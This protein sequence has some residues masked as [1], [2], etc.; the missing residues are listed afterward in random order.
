VWRALSAVL[1]VVAVVAVQACSTPQRMPSQP[2]DQLTQ[3][4]VLGIPN[5]RYYPDEQGAELFQEGMMSVQREMAALGVT[6][7]S[8]LP[9]AYYLAI[10]GGGGD[11][12]FGAGLLNG[13]TEA[14]TRPE[15]KLVTGISTGSLIAPFAFLGSDYDAQLKRVYTTIQDSDVYTERG[16][17]AVFDSDAMLD[18]TPLFGIISDIVDE[19]MMAAIAREYEKGRMLLVASTNLDARQ[20]VIWN[21]GA[22]AASGKPGALDLIH[23]IL[24][25]SAAMPVGFPP[26]MFDVEVDGVTYQEMH[27]DGGAVAQLILYP[28]AVGEQA[29]AMMEQQHITRE[30]VAYVIRNGRLSY[31]AAPVDRSTLTIA[32]Q[33]VSTMISS[34]GINDLYRVYFICQE[35]GVD[36]NLAYIDSGF[37]EPEPDDLFDKA[38][39]NDLFEYGYDLARNGYP[40]KKAPPYLKIE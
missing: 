13:W 1:V 40:W 35:D 12:A 26:V 2:P 28:P 18:T 22:I 38:Y 21:I 8:Q 10:S 36:Y 37:G 34:S 31:E 7:L 23:K 30:R 39:M 25:A 20:T 15:F 4:T 19:D 3:A 9:P 14:G 6:D 11:G 32:G 17:T 27:V 16:L 5:A 33:A 24:L 29:K